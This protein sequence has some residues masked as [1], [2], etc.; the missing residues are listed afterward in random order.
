M[1]AAKR[2]GPSTAYVIMEGESQIHDS[3]KSEQ[4][5]FQ[6]GENQIVANL[7]ARI[8]SWTGIPVEYG[9]GLQIAHYTNGGFFKA[10]YDYFNPEWGGG[11]PKAIERGGQRTHTIIIYL[12]DVPKES[13]GSTVFHKAD[14]TIQPQQG[15]AFL[16]MNVDKDGKCDESSYHEAMPI[17]NGSE[18][19]IA[20]KWIRERVF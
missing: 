2:L 10:H 8:A 3:R 9:E 6:L 16:F 4:M 7:E 20:T 1:M 19:W 12:N 11:A 14:I 13:G 5:F 18:K 17:L 15:L